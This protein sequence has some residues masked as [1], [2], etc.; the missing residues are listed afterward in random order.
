MLAY[1]YTEKKD[2]T[3]AKII[4][5]KIGLSMRVFSNFLSA[6]QELLLR[7]QIHRNT[8]RAVTNAIITVGRILTAPRASGVKIS[9]AANPLQIILYAFSFIS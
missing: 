1:L 9:T 2:E 8:R 4:K 6:V 3:R 5:I 7:A